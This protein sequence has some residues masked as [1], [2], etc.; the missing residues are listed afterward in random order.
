M[1]DGRALTLREKITIYRDIDAGI[2]SRAIAKKYGINF[3]TA[4]A[5]RHNPRPAYVCEAM[6]PKPKPVP[7]AMPGLTIAQLTGGRA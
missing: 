3:Q 2:P 4:V 7:N 5:M 6:L 1:I